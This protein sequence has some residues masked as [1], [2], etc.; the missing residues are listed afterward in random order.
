M[1]RIPPTQAGYDKTLKGIGEPRDAGRHLIN[2]IPW[3]ANILN[4]PAYP[5][6]LT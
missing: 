5:I 2:N 1:R 3:P 6:L 4:A